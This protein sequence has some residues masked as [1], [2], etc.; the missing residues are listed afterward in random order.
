MNRFQIQGKLRNIDTFVTKNDKTILTLV[1][2]VPGYGG[3]VDPVAYKVLGRLVPIAQGLPV[4]GMVEIT[5]KMG[6]R[7][8]NGRV[9]SELVAESVEVLGGQHKTEKAPSADDSDDSSIPF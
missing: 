7:E 2:E 6:G 1:L 4:G 3:R 9:F 8:S 5:G